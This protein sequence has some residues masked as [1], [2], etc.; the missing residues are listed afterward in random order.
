[1]AAG[2]LWAGTY[3]LQ[4]CGSPEQHTFRFST[5]LF[6]PVRP[7]GFKG[8]GTDPSPLHDNSGPG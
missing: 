1:M 8:Q 6:L 7:P 5:P 3:S 4:I 2:L